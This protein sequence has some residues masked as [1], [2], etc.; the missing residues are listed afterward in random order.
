MT[1][2]VGRPHGKNV[3]PGL[4]VWF[5]ESPGLSKTSTIWRSTCV[6]KTDP[7]VSFGLLVCLLSAS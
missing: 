6:S 7:L 5:N 2:T 1:N 3:S 4:L